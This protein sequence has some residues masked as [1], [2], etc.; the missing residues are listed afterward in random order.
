MKPA[1][2]KF[3]LASCMTGALVSS[4]VLAA[5]QVSSIRVSEQPA[6]PFSYSVD[7]AEYNWGRGDNQ[8]IEEFV[9]DGR[10]FGYVTS[11]NEVTVQRDDIGGITTGEPCGIFVERLDLNQQAFDYAAD[12]PLDSSVNGNCRLESLLESRII[13]RGI[14]DTFSNK[15]P[16]AKNIERLDYVFYYG[17]L[18]PVTEDNMRLAGHIV[19]EK[20]GNNPVKLAAILSLDVFGQPDEYGPL[21]RV[22]AAGCSGDELCYGATDL[23]HNYSFLQNEFNAPQGLPSETERSREVVNMAFVSTADLGLM[24]GQRYHGISIFAD[25]VDADV[26]NLIDPR[27]FPDDTADD[28]IVPGDGADIYGGL[29]GYFLSNDLNV[30]SG[31]LFLDVDLDGIQDADEA[32]IADVTVALYTDVNGDGMLDPGVD[33]QVGD[34][35][36]SN[37]DGSFV[38]PG[39]PDG[40]YLIVLDGA[41]P[42]IPAGLVVA[43][44][45]NPHP[46]TIAGG[47]SEPVNFAF[48]SDSGTGSG[49]DGDASGDGTDG[50]PGDGTDGEPG[51]GTDG[52]PGDGTDGEPGDGTDG[53][54][55]DGTDGGPGD[56]TDGGP[57]DGT[58]GGP[59][60]GT[61]G[62]PG[63]G[64][65]GEPGDGTDGGELDDG[66]DSGPGDG[67]DGEPGDGTD[68]EPG[69]GTDGEPGD[70]TDGE[71]GDGTDGGPNDGGPGADDDDPIAD[72]S[73]AANSDTF[74][75]NQGESA[76]LPVLFNDFDGTGT[77]S[78]T[79]TT[80]SRSENA[81][82]SITDD[83]QVLY[84]PDPGYFSI[85]NQPDTFTYTME[86]SDGTERTGNVSV[87]VV[88]FSDLNNNGENDFVECDCTD[89]FFETGVN[90]SGI[91]RMSQWF[92]LA[93]FL[94]GLWR[95]QSLQVRSP[96]ALK[97]GE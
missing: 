85:D 27:T 42:D 6:T 91:G 79:L 71:P 68:G 69:D 39:L 66:S 93:L 80:V 32:G 8:L 5:G 37:S 51:D 49:S 43:P 34:T 44:G 3:R 7:G 72:A 84:V 97:G 57:G 40:N 21:V 54:P 41:D 14:A 74:T 73:T 2:R 10:T 65:D 63:D 67:T 25:D 4:S 96:A 56:G 76:T 26:H 90:G 52:G 11:A 1:S 16:D 95:L 82:I 28:F 64:S 12:F 86:D 47:D 83:N 87:N 15:R 9:V 33:Q 18:A 17:A 36:L 50:R 70:G 24:P 62:G 58:D 60:D 31:A 23:V 20:K 92:M 48:I 55:G 61:D 89:L 30:A 75:I 38:F 29:T 19:A 46:A 94:F 45:I 59:G 81:A 77:D 53:G 22:A 88:R 78:L 13:N 35:V